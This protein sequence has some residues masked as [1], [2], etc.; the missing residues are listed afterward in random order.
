MAVETANSAS[1]LNGKPHGGS[2]PDLL[3]KLQAHIPKGKI[4]FERPP[5]KIDGKPLSETLLE[6][7]GTY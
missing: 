5:V 6:N 1:I 7:R 2:D 3:Q 4:S